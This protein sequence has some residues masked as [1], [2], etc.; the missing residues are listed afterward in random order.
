MYMYILAI[1]YGQNM[2]F[3]QVS[4]VVGGYQQP[5]FKRSAFPIDFSC[6]CGKFKLLM[7]LSTLHFSQ[8]RF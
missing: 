1:Y 4:V 3:F 6:I 5:L 7:E 2:I 8:V